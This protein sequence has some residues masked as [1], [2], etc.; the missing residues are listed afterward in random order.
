MKTILS[1]LTFLPFILNLVHAQGYEDFSGF[2]GG[3][4][5]YSNGTFTGNDG[6]E[7]TFIQCRGDLLITPPTPCLGKKRNPVSCIRSGQIG[8]GCRALVLRYR[9]A[10]SSAV[11]LD[12]LVNGILVKTLTTPGGITD[13][14]NT[15]TSDS[16]MVF[17]SGD[18]RMEFRQADSLL[19]GQVC[20]DDIAWTPWEQSVG[21][22]TCHPPEKDPLHV[23][24]YELLVSADDDP[25]LELA[26][27]DLNGRRVYSMTSRSPN[28]AVS[29]HELTGGAYLAVL[30]GRGGKVCSRKLFMICR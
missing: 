23:S 9:Q 5:T 17:A 6:S 2:Q 18:F 12:V 25:P 15:Y 29:L 4:G 20:I 28:F 11:N 30:S 8:N 21:T 24:G 13:T 16:I 14:S 27:T 10:F 22:G 19:S 3:S 1:F 7:W 26:V